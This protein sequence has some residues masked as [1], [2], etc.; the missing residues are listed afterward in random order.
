MV[1]CGG[2][3]IIMLSSRQKLIWE[4]V[5][6][7]AGAASVGEYGYSEVDQGYHYRSNIVNQVFLSLRHK[8]GM[9]HGGNEP[10]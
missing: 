6:S 9:F 10:I 8:W 7:D 1:V 2:H 5:N 4:I 3:M